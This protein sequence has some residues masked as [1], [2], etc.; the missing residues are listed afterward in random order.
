MGWLLEFIKLNSLLKLDTVVSKF[1]VD[2]S[3]YKGRYDDALMRIQQ[4]TN[5]NRSLARDVRM[6][7][8]LYI[9]KNFTVS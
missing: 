3:V 1:L 9:K 7:S 4:D 8:L 2:Y 5:T 6:A